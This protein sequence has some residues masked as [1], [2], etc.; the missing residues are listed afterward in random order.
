MAGTIIADYIRADANK[1]SLNVG[2]TTIATINAMGLL[3]NTN[4]VIIAADGSFN[5]NSVTTGTISKTIMAQTSMPSN[6]ICQIVRALDST[7][8]SQTANNTPQAAGSVTITPKYSNSMIIGLFN[9]ANE[10]SG[11]ANMGTRFYIRRIVGGTATD[12]LFVDYE[13]YDSATTS[14]LI[15]R[16]TLNF[17]D[18]PGTTSPVTYQ[19]FFCPDVSS[20]GANARMNQYGGPTS[21][22]VM[23]VSP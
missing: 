3:S 21:M 13:L 10:N 22:V 6:T 11:V 4:N 5:A 14:Q 20:A 23:E 17:T 9:I 12:V 19:Y 8:R 7:V 15:S 16:A 18:S 2:N 1:L